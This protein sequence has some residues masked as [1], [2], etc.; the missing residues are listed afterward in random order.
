MGSKGGFL[1]ASSTMKRS[2]KGTRLGDWASRRAT[3][4]EISLRKKSFSKE[5]PPSCRMVVQMADLYPR[6]EL[7]DSLR[8][9]DR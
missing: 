5:G 9:E 8:A 4:L 2:H 3:P 7:A 1:R 6:T